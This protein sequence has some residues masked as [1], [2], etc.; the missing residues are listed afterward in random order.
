MIFNAFE[1]SKSLSRE[2]EHCPRPFRAPCT[3]YSINF[4]SRA[5]CTNSCQVAC[6]CCCLIRLCEGS[7]YSSYYLKQ[8][9][10]AVS[11]LQ[12]WFRAYRQNKESFC[13]SQFPSCTS[14][15]G[16]I[17]RLFSGCSLSLPNSVAISL[18][19]LFRKLK[20]RHPSETLT[21]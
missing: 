20:V 10:R 11:K 8:V 17:Q 16:I 12:F 14:V 7:K 6:I 21:H 4:V 5:P 2:W 1:V 19:S 18:T 3:N 9:R 13:S 15:F